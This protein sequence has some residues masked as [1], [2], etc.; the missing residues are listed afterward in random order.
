M[1]GTALAVGDD[2][3]VRF[4]ADVLVGLS[5]AQKTI[6]A[7]Y[8]YDERGSA[9]FEEITTLHEYYPTR[10]ELAI[11][12]DNA[13]A[14]AAR[15]GPGARLLEYGSGASVKV[16]LLLDALDGP[17]AYVPVDI[18]RDHLHDAAARLADDY[19]ALEVL[20]LH[21][22]YTRPFAPPRTRSDGPWLGFFPGS[23]IG[24][25]TPPDAAAFLRQARSTL[26]DDGALVFGVD[27]RKAAAILDA[28]YND[29][30][31]VTA[32][33]NLNLLV[34]INRELDGDVDLDGFDH[35]AHWNEARGC[36]EMHLV[37]RRAQAFGVAG[38]RFAFA[39]GETIHTE[40]SHK[41]G[42]EEFLGLARAAGW[43]P[44]ETWTDADD[45][46]AVYLLA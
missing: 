1:W 29:A 32:A 21:A 30:R 13:A 43:H 42:L 45:L 31:G 4:R 33:F 16:R 38:R 10:T 8:F 19:P 18:S 39:E 28:A 36:V 11:L 22:D 44:R 35:R 27:R 17:H 34:R 25:F 37:S 41:Y 24:N 7:K 14:I 23:T 26:G 46:F 2:D 6:P 3:L 20:P 9:L 15:A 12:A 5:A 40:D